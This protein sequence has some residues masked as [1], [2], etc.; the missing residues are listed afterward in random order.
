M[1]TQLTTI[2]ESMELAT[3]FAKSGYFSDSRDASQAVVKI[4]AGRELGIGPMAS[5]MGI[6]I[7]EGKPSLSANLMASLIKGS[8]KYDYKI[9]QL[10]KRQCTLEFFES[11][12][13]V[14]EVQ[15]MLQ[16]FLDN[17]VAIMRDGKTLKRNWKSYPD[18]MLF[19]RAIS[20][21]FRR[22][23][24]DLGGG[25]SYY[26]DGEIEEAEF[27]EIKPDAEEGEGPGLL[28]N[29][30]KQ[31]EVIGT[32][33]VDALCKLFND[34]G[35]DWKKFTP[36]L[37]EKFGYTS[38]RQ[39]TPAEANEVETQIRKTIAFKKAKTPSKKAM[40]QANGEE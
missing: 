32:E 13:T 21:G 40:A 26:V 18:D 2:Q 3:Q 33:R 22:F 12:K 9:I 23:C 38:L 35:C 11:G 25:G 39:L 28:P 27:K 14:G 36:W 15:V 29:S 30:P 8:Q 16:D 34:G 24:S 4:F 5:M 31:E 17:G 7:I 20:K 19:A 37:E 10:D 1:G 6:H